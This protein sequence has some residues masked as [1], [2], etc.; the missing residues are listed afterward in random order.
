MRWQMRR[1]SEERV[2]LPAQASWGLG[3]EEDTPGAGPQHP[4]RGPVLWFSTD[5]EQFWLSVFSSVRGKAGAMESLVNGE[6]DVK[7]PEGSGPYRPVI[8]SHFT[9]NF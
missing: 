3:S 5:T 8:Y 6:K 9:I 2:Y 1:V 7:T 4:C